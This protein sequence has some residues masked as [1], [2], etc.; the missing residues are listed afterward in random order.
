MLCDVTPLYLKGR[1]LQFSELALPVRG[2]LG[3]AGFGSW[4][5]FASCSCQRSIVLARIATL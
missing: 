5:G 1:Y 2:Q 3:V 4:A